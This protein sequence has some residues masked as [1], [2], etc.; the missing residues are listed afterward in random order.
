VS[1]APGARQ[2]PLS[3]MSVR[4]P[5]HDRAW[6]GSVCSD[7]KA[8]TSCLILPRIA[9]EKNDDAEHGVRAKFWRDLPEAQWPGCRAERGAFM[10]PFPFTR[11]L[12]HPYAASSPAHKHFAPTPLAH[13]PYSLNCIP[14]NWMLTGGAAEQVERLEL[15]FD[16]E[17]ERA[18]HEEMRFDTSWVQVKKNQLLMLD[19][20]FSAVTPE[21]SLCFLYA[22][23][24]PLATDPRRVIVG[25]GRV[26]SVAAPVEYKYRE[27]GSH[28]AVLWDRIVQHS[29][30]PG[31]ADGFL[32]PYQEAVKLAEADPSIDLASLV[33]F[34]PEECW[35][36]FSYATEHVSHD[37]AVASLLAC[38]EALR[39]I[40]EVVPGPWA[41]QIA[42]IDTELN[43]IWKL[44]GPFPGFGS[45]LR[46][47]G[48]EGGNLIAYDLTLS[49]RQALAE[50]RE[51][52]WSLF[53]EAIADP[54]LLS[55]NLGRYLTDTV[56]KMY[57]A[58]APERRA[59]LRLLSRFD[60][61][62]DQATRFYQ[63]TERAKAGLRLTDADILANPYRIFEAD[64]TQVD[65]T[66]LGIIDR[67]LFPDAVVLEKHPLERPSAM[68]GAL[69]PR[70]ARALLVH[71]LEKSALDGHTLQ[72]RTAL[73][74]MVRDLE[75]RPACPLGLDAMAVIAPQLEP[76]IVATDLAD[77]AVALQLQRF[78]DTQRDIRSEVLKRAK[79][80]PHDGS[81]D[82]RAL[83]DTALPASDGSVEEESA[84]QE[85][86]AALEQLYRSRLSVLVGPAGTGKTTL[87]RVLCE[88]PNVQRGEILLLAPTGKA[89][90]RME[91]QIGIAGAQTI[92]QFLVRLKRYDP[93]TG[94]YHSSDHPKANAA[95]TVIIDESSM[96][97]EEQLAAVLDAMHPP[98]RLILVGDPSQLPPIGS[99]R[100]FVDIVQQV[101]PDPTTK[102]FPAVAPGYAELTIRRRQT[103]QDRPDLTLAEWFSG[104]PLGP[105]ADAVWD[106]LEKGS[107]SACLRLVRWDTEE[108]LDRV[109]MDVLQAELKLANLEDEDGFERSLG[110]QPYGNA[111][112]FN[113]KKDPAESVAAHAEDWQILSPVR[114]GA[115]GVERLNRSIQTRFRKRVAAWAEPE[116]YWQR[117]TPPPMGRQGILY[118]DKVISV[119]NG[120]REDM[121][122]EDGGLGYVANGEIGI[123]LGQYKGMKWKPKRLPWKLEVE[124]ASQKGAKYGYFKGDFGEERDPSLELAYALTIHKSQ[125]SE[126]N[127]VVL[128]APNPCRLLSPELLYTALTRQRNRIVVLHQGPLAEL[129]NYSRGHLSETARRLTNLFEAPTLAQVESRFLEDRLIHRTRRGEAVRSKSEVVIADLLFSLK[130]DYRYEQP[131]V[132]DDG[133][134]RLPDFTI[135]DAASGLKI[136]WEHL[137]MLSLP[138]YQQQWHNKL[139]WYRE[140]DVKP[141]E[142]GGGSAG[143]LVTSQDDARGGIDSQQIEQIARRALG[144]D[145]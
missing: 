97:T 43:R 23:D 32:F 64:R 113:F 89:R 25:V 109:L 4:V 88:Q 27:Q 62:E 35:S 65:P 49:Q 72:P 77:G 114:G 94:R 80:K 107:Q 67:G 40:G 76:E 134:R 125:G 44:R 120:R 48:V 99:G 41:Q 96:L 56:R 31:F 37:G 129:K 83:V 142:E 22:K 100:P 90:V 1:L 63:E 58:L 30:R 128:V 39:R 92:A 55:G 93:E 137:G 84:R 36:Q 12:T 7:P 66:P 85:K 16:D 11:V 123:V 47:F 52:P 45:A 50:W 118:G 111:V 145:A 131:L 78:V 6:D 2:L 28:T 19:T 82:W 112:Y 17:A 33:A 144:L 95:K 119:R 42:W 8:N 121:W 59:L 13:E 139:A 103:G 136:F 26:K 15:P 141:L 57:R 86:A 53:D 104:R 46:A 79:G 115:P 117:K 61:S 74:Q 101:A 69:D 143:T 18:V 140:H 5:W 130:A 71:E 60:L 75:I 29:I 108:E 21:E 127:T 124:F 10:A 110:G 98:E 81:F 132:M 116:T 14:F 51:D 135:D 20:F 133:S 105:S 138:G 38:V 87:L 9:K 122:P 34:A 106:E 68:D 24:T 91:T 73:I 70:R 102:G 3:H 126:F 54:S